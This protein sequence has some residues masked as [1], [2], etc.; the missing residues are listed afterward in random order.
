MTTP[1]DYPV[2]F[3]SYRLGISSRLVRRR[4]YQHEPKTVSPCL[5]ACLF[6]N[7][8]SPVPAYLTVRHMSP[9]P[10]ARPAAPQI[11]SPHIRRLA[12][13]GM[14]DGKVNGEGVENHLP[15]SSHLMN[16]ADIMEMRIRSCVSTSILVY[17]IYRYGL[18]AQLR[19]Q[20]LC[21]PKVEGWSPS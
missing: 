12:W 3:F 4:R 5:F 11:V 9:R 21:T 15:A 8:R 14:D 2:A 6:A 19:E 13:T 16:C 17:Y 10:P 7:L 18:V 20:R 1:S